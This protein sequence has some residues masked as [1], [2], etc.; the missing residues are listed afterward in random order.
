MIENDDFEVSKISGGKGIGCK[1]IKKVEKKKT[2]GLLY[3]GVVGWSLG[4]LADLSET[5]ADLKGELPFLS[6]SQLELRFTRS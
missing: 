5:L 6:S 1:K 3:H 4:K 2:T